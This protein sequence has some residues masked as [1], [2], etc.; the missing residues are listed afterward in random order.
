MKAFG[1]V[2]FVKTFFIT[3]EQ[4]KPQRLFSYHIDV[5]GHTSTHARVGHVIYVARGGWRPEEV[6]AL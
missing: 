3:Q 2:T 1:F 4:K 6:R 5:C